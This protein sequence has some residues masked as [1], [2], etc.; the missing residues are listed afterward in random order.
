MCVGQTVCAVLADT[1]AHAKRGAAAVK[2][3]YED[4]PDAIFTIEVSFCFKPEQMF[5]VTAHY[6]IISFSQDAIEKSSYYEP[7][8]MV[9]KGDVTEAFK[10]VDRVYEG[11]C[12]WINISKQH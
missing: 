12:L 4:L 7:R 6:S 9:A 8:R 10:S 3:T 11:K 5:E 2:I 1:K